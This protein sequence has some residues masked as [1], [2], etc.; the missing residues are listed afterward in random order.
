[1]TA[2]TIRVLLAD[3]HAVMREGLVRL[4]EQELDIHVIGEAAD[5]QEAVDLAGQLLADV[6]LMDLN[7]PRLNGIDATRALHA[8]MPN[9]RI[10]GLS[11]YEEADQAQAMIQAGAACYCTKSC[12]ASELLAAIRSAV[13]A[14]ADSPA[15]R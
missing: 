5:G 4:L 6:V 14:E 7:M 9:V 12:P 13:G 2:Q 3:D 10:I 15:K 11:M 8:R 1:M